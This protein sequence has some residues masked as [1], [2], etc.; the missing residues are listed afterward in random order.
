MTSVV[1]TGTLSRWG[2]QQA[3]DLVRK[4]GG[5][6]TSSVSRKTDLVVVGEN[7]GSKAEKAR[8]L[9]IEVLD[10]EAFAKFAETEQGG[11]TD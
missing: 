6:P 1:V 3:Q 8:E 10:E 2:R 11:T 4:L 9:G 5:K 7:P